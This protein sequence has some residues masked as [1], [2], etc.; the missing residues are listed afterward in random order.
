MAKKAN[1]NASNLNGY[2]KGEIRKLERQLSIGSLV[3]QQCGLQ[4]FLS[5]DNKRAVNA[6]Q[7]LYGT[8]YPQVNIYYSESSFHT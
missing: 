1:D 8:R 6:A 5:F 7:T 3:A 4:F 2:E